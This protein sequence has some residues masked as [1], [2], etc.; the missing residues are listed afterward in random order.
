[1][2]RLLRSIHAK[3][4]PEKYI[5]FVYGDVTQE[6]S[7]Y[8]LRDVDVVLHLAASIETG[9]YQ[10]YDMLYKSNVIGTKNVAEAAL[11]SD[12]VKNF[13]YFSS[14]ATIG[15]RNIE[16]F[17]TEDI[18]CKPDTF[19]GMTKYEAELLL[20]KLWHENRL[21]VTILRLPTVYGAREQ[22]NFRK[23]I[24]AIKNRKFAF[25]GNGENLTSVLYVKNLS[26]EID[27][28]FQVKGGG[29]I[30]H[31]A[32]A[33]P[34]SWKKLVEYISE[35]LGIRP[36]SLYIPTPLAKGIALMLEMFAKI[37]HIEPP[38]HRGRVKTLTSN[39]AFSIEKAV[40][41]IGYSPPY[42]TRTGIKE[43]VLSLINE[44][45]DNNVRYC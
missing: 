39:F 8:L 1:M 14:M 33:E 5:E 25:I 38:L 16:T 43:T 32:D 21:P 15:I 40:K 2:Q 18:E 11:A 13:I 31:L 10:N 3:S 45:G 29:E 26:H 41:R 42:P 34:I 6:I 36:P 19:Y 37:L 9:Y 28:F 12:S 35:A 30:Y 22:Y 23:L 24:K 17:V 7:K 4:S 27:K 20:K 44:E